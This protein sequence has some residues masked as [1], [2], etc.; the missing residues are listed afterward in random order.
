MLPICHF[1]CE[2]FSKFNSKLENPQL[3]FWTNQRNLTFPGQAL[4]FVLVFSNC[5]WRAF[6]NYGKYRRYPDLILSFENNFS[7]LTNSLL[8][9]K[10]GN[11]AN[12]I[13]YFVINFFFLSFKK[14]KR[15]SKL[16]FYFLLLFFLSKCQVVN[17]LKVALKI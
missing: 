10:F 6:K 2:L 16:T 9:D 5:G 14:W 4:F 11:T 13:I 7:L 12:R 8:E 1:K 3:F 15:N 17:L